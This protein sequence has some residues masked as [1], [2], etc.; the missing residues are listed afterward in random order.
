MLWNSGRRASHQSKAEQPKQAMNKGLAISVLG[1]IAAH[2]LPVS[3]AILLVSLNLHGY[4]IGGELAGPIGYDDVKLS[5]LQFSAKL[6]EITMQASLSVI[7]VGLIRQELVAGEGIPFGAIFGSLQFTDISY[8][9]S[10]EFV[11]TLR[12]KF[13]KPIVKIRLIGLLVTGALLAVSVGPSSAI[14]MRPRIDNWPAGGTDFYLNTTLDQIWPSSLD[15]SDILDSCHNVTLNTDCIS[16]GWEALADQLLA[17]W[18]K[19]TDRATMPESLQITSPES[20]RLMY[21]RETKGLFF[22][23]ETIATTQMS[24]LADSLAE[25]GRLWSI[26]ANELSNVSRQPRRFIYRN[27]AIYTLNDVYQP[28]TTAICW[29]YRDKLDLQGGLFSNMVDV[30]IAASLCN[31]TRRGVSYSIPSELSTTIN[32]YRDD[33]ASSPF[34]QFMELPSETFGNNT[35]GALI[36]FPPSWPGGSNLLTCTVDARWTPVN[37]QST[38]E[39]IKVVSGQPAGWPGQGLCNYSQ[40]SISVT[41]EWAQYLNPY[42]QSSNKT[43]FDTLLD[44]IAVQPSEWTDDSGF[45]EGLMESILTTMITSGLSRTAS[46]ATIQGQLKYCPNNDCDEVCGLWCLDMMPSSNQE[47]GYGGDIYNLSGIDTSKLSKFTVQV[48]VN[49]YA[50][51]SRGATMILSCT[52]LILYCLLASIHVTFVLVKRTN[53]NAWDSVSEVTALAMQSQP[54]E[55][56]KNTCAGISTSRIFSNL[57]RVVRTG[58]DGDHLEL[59]FGDHDPGYGEPLVEDDFYG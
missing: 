20:I 7:V 3:A 56:L 42:I 22:F 44:S 51:N 21:T 54:T 25:I 16:A 17:Y 2:L 37:L 32:A 8:L 11:G 55:V 43:V 36:S 38:R 28:I 33:N 52:I 29:A 34:L 53:S 40:P 10:K 27:D 59:D 12:A 19:M 30:P 35:I 4:Y 48:D 13:S 41:S 50:Y 5:G 46:S 23:F 9:Y 58:V 18:P 49:G 39:I 15:A 6:H 26:A 31:D 45:A 47:F 1:V 14:A 57:V 24:I